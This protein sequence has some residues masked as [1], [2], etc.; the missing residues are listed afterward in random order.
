MSSFGS[1]P[2][3]AQT[4]WHDPSIGGSAGVRFRR[5][6]SLPRGHLRQHSPRA[7]PGRGGTFVTMRLSLANRH[8]RGEP[9]RR[10][11]GG[12]QPDGGPVPATSHRGRR[13]IKVYGEARPVR[14][15]HEVSL[16]VWP[17]E[18]VGVV[19]ESGSGKT[20]LAH[21]IAGIIE[22]TSGSMWLDQRPICRQLERR[23]ADDLRAIQLVFQNPDSALNRGRRTGRILGHSVKKLAGLRGT[24]QRRRVSELMQ[25]V[26]IGDRHLALRPRDLSGGLKQR[27]AIAAAI[28]TNAAKTTRLPRNMKLAKE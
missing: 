9:P 19:G 17:G 8:R 21:A 14:A 23:P 16:R 26:R 18:T 20:T 2:K 24:E 22:A 15:L 27:V 12:S 11:R 5:S 28:R 1:C 13:I 3:R 25:S 4:K 6:L 10:E 7:H